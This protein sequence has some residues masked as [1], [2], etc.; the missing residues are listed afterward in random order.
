MLARMDGITQFEGQSDRTLNRTSDKRSIKHLADH[1]AQ[2]S[3]S[4][5]IF[6]LLDWLTVL[7]IPFP[8]LGGEVAVCVE[9][10][11]TISLKGIG[12]V[13]LVGDGFHIVR[14]TPL[15][16]PTPTKY[17]K[18]EAK[19][20]LWTFHYFD[21]LCCRVDLMEIL[22]KSLWRGCGPPRPGLCSSRVRKEAGRGA[23]SWR[24]FVVDAPLIPNAQLCSFLAGELSEDVTCQGRNPPRLA[25]CA[26]RSQTHNLFIML[27]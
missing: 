19:V 7:V 17:P 21:I 10:W 27:C 5:W 26:L 2:R 23:A 4:P 14:C 8:W 1:L 25:L 12:V 11:T 20:R 6:S 22:S 9:Y 16:V 18:A 3:F 13:F 15:R 24:S